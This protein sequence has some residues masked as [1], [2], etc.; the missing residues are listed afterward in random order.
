MTAAAALAL[1]SPRWHTLAQAYGAAGDVPRLLGHLERVTDA[2]RA[3]LW[4]GLWALLCA[5]G[6][7]Y[8][9]SYAAVPHLVAFAARRPLPDRAQA[10]H[11]IGAIEASRH[12]APAPAVPD[13]VAA[14][15]HAAVAQ[16]APLIARS[17]D[18]P[19]DAD[20]AQ[21][22]A[23]VLAIAK[24]HPRFGTA[25]LALEP[26]IVCPVCGAAHATPGWGG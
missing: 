10:L 15:Y 24:G 14:P 17:V 6:R 21:V 22:L 3:E 20:T 4:F 23:S 1:D 12:G 7:V 2:E 9:A 5:G 11:L 19:W 13:D 8:S 26:A 18:E 16:V 25:A